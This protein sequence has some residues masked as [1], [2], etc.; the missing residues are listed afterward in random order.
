LTAEPAAGSL[1][2]I[3]G[4][5]RE[6]RLGT[7]IA[8]PVL[9]ALLVPAVATAGMAGPTVSLGRAGGLEYLKATYE[10]VVS[11][12][13]A[14]AVCD[15]GDFATGGGGAINGDP[16]SA[17]LSVIAPTD[18]PDDGW[19]AKGAGSGTP[20]KATTY[21]IC[22]RDITDTN[23]STSSFPAGSEFSSGEECDPGDVSLS[24]GVSANNGDTTI[25][26][27][28][29]DFQGVFDWNNRFA[30]EADDTVARHVV[31]SSE[32]ARTVR[33]ET[34]SVRKDAAPKVVRRCGRGDAVLGGGF[35]VDNDELLFPFEV[36]AIA[37]RPWDDPRDANKVPEDG[38]LAK[39]FN[40]T[41][42]RLTVKAFA[43]CAT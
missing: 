17:E 10:N 42:A 11:Q 12:A 41:G 19:I 28:R 37:S 16:A 4:T 1:R 14:P 27:I 7:G 25:A 36:H 32:Y 35:E 40:D 9:A 34:E 39:V 3:A 31:C 24:G 43:V 15:P 29:P 33:R 22:G 6:R 20:R 21:A 5:G 13:G 26:T 18:T 2:T 23:T 38:W 8:L 30:V